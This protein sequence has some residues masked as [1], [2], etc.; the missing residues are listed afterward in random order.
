MKQAKHYEFNVV[1]PAVPLVISLY[2]QPEEVE[3]AIATEGKSL[4]NQTMRALVEA[5]TTCVDLPTQPS[6]RS[7]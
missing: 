1:P 5:L 7:E 6:D 4:Q 3:L 2:L